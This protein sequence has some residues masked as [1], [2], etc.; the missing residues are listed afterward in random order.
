MEGTSVNT[1]HDK[2]M[3]K[4]D[5]SSFIKSKAKFIPLIINV[6]EEYKKHP[7]KSVLGLTNIADI[8]FDEDI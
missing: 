8:H 1:Y 2:I 3:I 4:A 6:A 5:Y 7:P